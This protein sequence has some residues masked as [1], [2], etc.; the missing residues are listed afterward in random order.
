MENG[1]I[2][3][4]SGQREAV[5]SNGSIQFSQGDRIT[6][7]L[8]STASGGETDGTITIAHTNPDGSQDNNTV[9][10]GTLVESNHVGAAESFTFQDRSAVWQYENGK[11][12]L[13]GV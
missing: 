4:K 5:F 7:E 11:Y 1:I 13:V 8:T 10:S 2:R 6:I 9:L 12:Y 3:C